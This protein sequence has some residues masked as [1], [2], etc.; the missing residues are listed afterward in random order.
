MSD[1]TVP[2]DGWASSLTS[3]TL[4]LDEL[5]G[6]S[7]FSK[8]TVRYYIQLGLVSRPVGA[9][10]AARYTGEHLRQLRTIKELTTVGL[11]L[12][13]IRGIL[14][15]GELPFPLREPRPGSME[16]RGHVYVGPGLE[17]QITPEEARLTPEQTRALIREVIKLAGAAWS[18]EHDGS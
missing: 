10:R 14:A 8:R 12:Q 9:A 4:S 11:S 5:C 7:G 6:L 1:K 17:L 3:E 2:R 18:G 13:R 15:D 16:M